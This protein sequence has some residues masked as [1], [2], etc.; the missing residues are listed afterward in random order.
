MI[1]ELATPNWAL[2]SITCQVTYPNGGSVT[3][4]SP[5]VTFNLKEG[6]A[7]TCTFTNTQQNGTL[8]VKKVVVNDDGGTAASS[9]WDIHVKKSGTD[10]ASSPQP[11]T[12]TGTSY[13]LPAGSYNVSETGGVTGYEQTS[14][15]GDCAADGSVT[16]AAGQTKTCTITNDDV[17]P[18]LTLI[19]KVTNNDGGTAVANDFTLTATAADPDDDRNFSIKGGVG[20]AAD[21]FAGVGYTLGESGPAGYTGSAWSCTGGTLVDGVVTV[22][23][24]GNAVCTITNTD[25]TPKLTL[26]K[27]VEGGTNVA[28]DWT[29]SAAATDNPGTRNFSDKG[30]SGTSHNVWAGATYSLSESGPGGYTASDWVCT[31]TGVQDGSTITLGLGD[32]A[33][34]TI[35]NTRDRGSIEL[36]K[37]WSGT[38]GTVTLMIGVAAGGNTVANQSVTGNGTTGAKAVDTGEYFVSESAL[39]NYDSSVTCSSDQRDSI[40][41]TDKGGVTVQKGEHVVCVYVNTRHTG[42][43]SVTKFHDRNANGVRNDVDGGLQDWSFWL[44]LD[45]DKVKD[46]GEPTAT[47]GAD[48]TATFAALDTGTYTVCE[49]TKDGWFASLPRQTQPCVTVTVT[50]NGTVAATFGNYR[51]GRIQVNKTFDLGPVPTGRTY[52]FEIRSG[53]STTAMGT[54]VATGSVTGPDNSITPTEWSN[55]G[56]LEPGTYSLCEQV[57]SGQ[58]PNWVQERTYGDSG[59]FTPG[60]VGGAGFQEGENT[61]AC[62]NFTVVSTEDAAVIV[63]DVN[64][65][66]QGFAHTIGYWKNWTSCD[67]AGSQ[68]AMLDLMIKGGTAPDGRV[69]APADDSNGNGLP[70]IRIGDLYIEGPYA[71][72]MAVDILDKRLVGTLSRI[73]DKPKA[74]GDPIIN[75]TAQL[76]AYE[77]NQM[78]NYGST[79]QAACESKA[80]E[81]AALMQRFLDYVNYTAS[82]YKAPTSALASVTVQ[83]TQIKANMLYLA[84]ILDDYNNNTMANC[85]TAITLPYPRVGTSSTLWVNYLP[86][87]RDS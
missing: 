63:F 36:Q 46:A 55:G 17:A 72:Q 85:L 3:I 74:A 34:C 1:G 14:I 40:K 52:T 16:V 70:D 11:G 61:L 76:L 48:G 7:R 53:A 12:A 2:T 66:P 60:I 81:A 25:N 37:Q 42:S 62:I 45:G 57:V 77:L 50:K 9:A 39:A 75:A 79:G 23:L 69:Y 44:D 4:A 24:G 80:D 30:G 19:K 82:G 73:G 21:V 35:T 65:V 6:E 31:G 41:P 13:T 54:V 28:N 5:N 27:K 71:C 87:A 26:I 22:A 64:N 59:W 56:W 47:T 49:V 29:L 86:A 51:K 10:V 58:T 84:E 83:T 78:L 20:S 18:M 32:S 68:F 43:I 33:T 38:P 67:G 8:I 15:S